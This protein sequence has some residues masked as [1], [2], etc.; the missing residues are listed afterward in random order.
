MINTKA[1]NTYNVGYPSLALVDNINGQIQ[2]NS[3]AIRTPKKYWT[4][5]SKPM[6]K[7]LSTIKISSNQ[8]IIQ[9][10]WRYIKLK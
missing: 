4:L 10:N 2:P 7:D 1:G 6:K 5:N 3:N 8:F 9:N